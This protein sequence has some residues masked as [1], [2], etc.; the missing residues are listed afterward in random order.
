MCGKEGGFSLGD[1]HL[2]LLRALWLFCGCLALLMFVPS[3]GSILSGLLPLW[4][5][6][7]HPAA[8]WQLPR[9]TCSIA[10][11]CP[12][13]CAGSGWMASDCCGLSS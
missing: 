5:S 4:D 1:R 6:P 2:L 9:R 7:V 13:A 11:V 3:G 12:F 8:A 10:R